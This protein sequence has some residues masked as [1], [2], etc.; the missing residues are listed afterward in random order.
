MDVEQWRQLSSG[1]APARATL[2]GG[3]GHRKMAF[4]DY[5]HGP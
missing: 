4:R 1:H 3:D 2:R 5:P